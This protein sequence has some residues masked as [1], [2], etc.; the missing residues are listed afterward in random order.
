LVGLGQALLGSPSVNYETINPA[1][2]EFVERFA[3]MSDQDLGRVV[4]AAHAAF[5][6]WR[7]RGAADRAAFLDRAAAILRANVDEYAG[8]LTLEMGKR[9][10]EARFEVTLCANI[11]EYYAKRA[12]AHL[13]PTA[14]AEVPNAEIHTEP[15]GVLLAI[16]PW[17]FP[18]YQI[19]RVVAPQL[20]V[21]NV[22]LLKHAESVPQSALAFARLLERAEVPH[23]VYTNVFASIEQV[24]RLID[25]SRVRGVTLTGSERAGAAVA[26]RAGRNMK[27]T[28]LE[29]G[30]SDPLIVLEDAPLDWAIGC[31][32]IG[33]MFNTG[34]CCVGSK[35][36]IVVGKQ[37]SAAFLEGFSNRMSSLKA[38]DPADVATSLGP[39]SSE[40]ALNTL[41]GQ[42]ERAK[43][44]GS[45]VVTGGRKVERPG[46]YLEPTVLA[47][48]DARNP[49]YKEELFGPIAAFYSVR[50]EEEAI[51]LAND[52]PYGLGASVFTEDLD[53][54]RRVAARIESGMVF[55]NQPFR[56][57]ADLPF[58]GIKNS[59]Y[60][61]E[62]S[63]AGF[64]EFVNK[65]LVTS[66]PAGTPPLPAPKPV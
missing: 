17:N 37:R 15:L 16:E 54:G 60:G 62:L 56:T 31:A 41:L 47:E 1:T 59:G 22:L 24:G 45:K 2:G 30:G 48:I 39:V 10:N 18:Y 29:L 50:N 46:F 61:R 55:V 52:T 34:Q 14:L 40:R 21:G 28:V 26:E 51:K 57:A 32:V 7:H 6:D 35:R 8:Y 53:R 36:I 38:G 25:D 63:L 66:V 43:T 3:T 27:K 65:K 58:G 64:D 12:V 42:L 5:I 19:A 33:R 23:G 4:D 20:A 49:I 44:G 13:K 11:F 9:L